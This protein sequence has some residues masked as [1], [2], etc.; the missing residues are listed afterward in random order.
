MVPGCY[1]RLNAG[2]LVETSTCCQNTATENRMIENLKI[3]SLLV[4]AKEYK[5]D[6]F[7]FDLMN[8]HMVS[9]LVNVRKALDLLTMKRGGVDGSKIIVYGKDGIS[10]KSPIAA[11][12]LT[13]NR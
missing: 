7:R 8:H 4:W 9:N 13:F 3:D 10:A 11:A 12:A 5:V 6:G 2:G 1:H